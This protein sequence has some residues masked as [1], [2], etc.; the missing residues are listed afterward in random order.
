MVIIAHVDLDSFF[1][2]CERV[3]D[4]ELMDK[5]I[6]I[7]MYSGRGDDAGA[8]STAGYNARDLGIGA[9][10]PIKQAKHIAADADIDVAFLPADKAYYKDVSA[11]VM[12]II[13]EDIT[14]VEV[15]SVDE[16]YVD[17]SDCET[18][19]A[20]AEQVERIRGR[21]REDEGLTASAGIGPNKLIAKMA[22]DEN[23]PDGQT[24][25]RPES[26]EQFLADRPVDDLYGVGAK[27]A[28][29]LDDI[30]ITTIDELAATPVQHLVSVFGDTR[31]VA[32]HDKAHGRG[33]E[34]LEQREKKQLSRITT[35]PQDTRSMSDIRPV[36]RDLAADVLRRVT[37]HGVH[38]GSVSAIVITADRETRTRSTT[39]PAPTQSEETLY[40]TAERLVTAFLEEHPDLAVRRVGVRTGAFTDEK[41][42][43]L[44]EF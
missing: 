25:V 19:D 3:R 6:V 18:F 29:Q 30:G 8:V 7:C 24:V 13:A 10:M 36:I 11:R 39:L 23:K 4:P 22:S 12:Q 31:G 21:I 2:S 16:A 33:A 17:L 37:S 35:L 40:Q 26:V 15:A 20:A 41:Q 1:A 14:E 43:R 9:A 5:G 44:G 42:A 38:F 27:T 34:T 32:L 28:D